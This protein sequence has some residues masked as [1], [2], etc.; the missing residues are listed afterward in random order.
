MIIEVEQ[1]SL[2]VVEIEVVGGDYPVVEVS[3]GNAL[4]TEI[5]LVEAGPAG[6]TGRV[7]DASIGVLNDVALTAPT[8]GDI[9]VYSSNKF[10]NRPQV[11]LVDGG[12]F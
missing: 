1:I 5:I 9:L 12:N 6:P 10:R 8:D 4:A 2:G 3:A 7:E 11:E